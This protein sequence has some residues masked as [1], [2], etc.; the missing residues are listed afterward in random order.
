MQGACFELLNTYKHKMFL[1]TAAEL[2]CLQFSSN[3]YLEFY[4]I[5]QNLFIVNRKFVKN[6]SAFCTKKIGQLFL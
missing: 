6:Y 1:Y 5:I 3:G 4:Y 2:R